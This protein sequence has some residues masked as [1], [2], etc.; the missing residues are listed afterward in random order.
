MNRGELV[1]YELLNPT[2]ITPRGQQK[3]DG[4]LSKGPSAHAPLNIGFSNLCKVIEKKI[5]VKKKGKVVKL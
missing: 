1:E 2:K 5:D 4:S 3:A